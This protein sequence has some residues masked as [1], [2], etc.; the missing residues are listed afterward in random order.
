MNKPT[1]SPNFTIDDIHM[2]REWNYERRKDMSPDEYLADVA[3]GAAKGQEMI[4]QIRR[5]KYP[6]LLG[7]ERY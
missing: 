3:R 1:L 7:T 4:D 6:D 5:E 2:L